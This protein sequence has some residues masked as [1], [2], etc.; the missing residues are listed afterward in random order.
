MRDSYIYELYATNMKHYGTIIAFLISLNCQSQST[1]LYNQIFTDSVITI[2][3]ESVVQGAPKKYC[4]LSITNEWAYRRFY[5]QPP[6]PGQH[7][8]GMNLYAYNDSFLKQTLNAQEWSNIAHKALEATPKRI[9]TQNENI[10][11][12]DDPNKSSEAIFFQIT[13]PIRHKKYMMIDLTYYM[14]APPTTQERFLDQWYQGQALLI[15]NKESKREWK[16]VRIVN[17]FIL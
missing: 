1:Q 17:R 5:N 14:K 13:S 3:L 11:L 12:V 9:K 4:L 8:E 15:F 2:A 6:G 16:L 10:T 7:A